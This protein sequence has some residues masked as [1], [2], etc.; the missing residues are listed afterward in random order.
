MARIPAYL[1]KATCVTS[2]GAAKTSSAAMSMLCEASASRTPEA[3][4]ATPSGAAIRSS[5]W[6]A[7]L[8]AAR[9]RSARSTEA[10]ST[11]RWSVT[12]VNAAITP[13]TGVQFSSVISRS[14]PASGR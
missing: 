6:T 3:A 13:S 10:S 12:M 11:S 7:T 5:S 4:T 9:T 2:S 8:N 1:R 14:G